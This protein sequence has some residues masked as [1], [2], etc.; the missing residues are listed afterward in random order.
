MRPTLVGLALFGVFFLPPLFVFACA[1]ILCVRYRAWE[2][3]FIGLL[4]DY[5]WLPSGSTFSMIPL[6]TL[7]AIAL[8]WLFEPLRTQFLD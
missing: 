2:V 5:L 8:V 7:I 6:A 4:M 3:L 1:L